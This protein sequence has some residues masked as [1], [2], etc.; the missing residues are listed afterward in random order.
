MKKIEINGS[1]RSFFLKGTAALGAGLASASAGAAGLFDSPQTLQQQ[2][3]QL[4]QKLSKLEDREA[5]KHLYLAFTA[6]LENRNYGAVVELFAENASV[7]LH[8]ICLEGKA[9]VK[10]LF[11]EGYGEQTA[12]SLHTAHRRD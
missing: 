2:I 4:Q 9:A 3:T 5:L 12:S 8:G 7:E 11:L 6:L 10:K 1:R